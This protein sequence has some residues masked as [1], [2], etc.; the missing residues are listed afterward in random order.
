MLL[1]SACSEE[2]KTPTAVVDKAAISQPSKNPQASQPKSVPDSESSAPQIVRKSMQNKT[3]NDVRSSLG[4]LSRGAD[5]IATMRS[6]W[7]SFTHP[8]FAIVRANP[9]YLAK[10]IDSASDSLAT[11]LRDRSG[12]WNADSELKR[13]IIGRLSLMTALFG[14]GDSNLADF[15]QIIADAAQ[16]TEPTEEDLLT[17][18]VVRQAVLIGEN[19]PELQDSNLPAWTQLATSPNVACRA[20]A[21]IAFE[22]LRANPKQQV[23]FYRTYATESS[24]QIAGLFIER[25]VS[26]GTPEA[27]A[28]LRQ[29][30]TT[31]PVGSKFGTLIDQ[32]IVSLQAHH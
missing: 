3:L 13:A 32:K 28:L 21:L 25:V 5:V 4:S 14:V 23:L 10:T 19:R 17:L 20:V 26:S 24:P 31:S 16:R 29:F 15:P 9:D 30:K 6:G 27:E 22:A 7:N 12:K 1:I 8:S 2:K 11:E 18:R